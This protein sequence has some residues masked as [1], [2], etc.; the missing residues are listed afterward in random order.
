[1]YLNVCKLHRKIPTCESLFKDK[2]VCFSPSAILMFNILM[3]FCLLQIGKQPL[4]KTTFDF[5]DKVPCDKARSVI[6]NS[7]LIFYWKLHSWVEK[8]IDK[9]KV[10]GIVFNKCVQWSSVDE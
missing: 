5:W 6:I 7:L 8:L 9:Q 1:M 3:F 10:R 2:S 4:S